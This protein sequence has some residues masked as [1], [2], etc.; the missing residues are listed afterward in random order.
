MADEGK[1][2]YAILRRLEGAGES[3]ENPGELWR[4]IDVVESTGREE[5]R[6]GYVDKR[7][8]RPDEVEEGAVLKAVS[9]RHWDSDDEPVRYERRRA[10]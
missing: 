7:I 2:R 3:E 5:A 1:T 8:G 6:Q 9:F 10:R 4:Q